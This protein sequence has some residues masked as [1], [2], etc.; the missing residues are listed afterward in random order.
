MSSYFIALAVNHWTRCES[1]I[2]LSFGNP[3]TGSIGFC[4]VF[5]AREEA[6]KAYPDAMIQGVVVLKLEEAKVKP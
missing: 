4:E 1:N 3:E 5:T 6:E 2:G